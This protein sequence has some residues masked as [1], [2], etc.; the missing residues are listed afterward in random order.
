M[1]Q[2]DVR[3]LYASGVAPTKEQLDAFVDDIET[4]INLTKLNDDNI[5][6]AGITA[7]DKFVDG[8][9]TTAKFQNSAVT[10]AKIADDAVTAVKIADEAVTAGVLA[11][12]SVTTAKLADASITTDKFAAASVTPPKIAGNLQIS[13]GFNT[14]GT[15]TVESVSITTTG[16]PI[17][18]GIMQNIGS[19]LCYCEATFNTATGGNIVQGPILS[20][21][22]GSTRLNII[23]KYTAAHQTSTAYMQSVVIPLGGFQYVDNQPAGT[24]TYSFTVSYGGVSES[25]RTVG[26]LYAL[27]L[28]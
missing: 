1:A 19:G 18:I 16:G 28:H 6:D 7:S 5:Q 17:L 3:R 8:T 25:G 12:T 11:A 14:T 2:L 15:G 13:P 22:R 21:F 4:F 26:A 24:Y 23:T 10:T 27:E 9:V 20:L